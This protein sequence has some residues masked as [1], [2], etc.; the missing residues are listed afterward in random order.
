M[1]CDT[2]VTFTPMSQ[3]NNS[4]YVFNLAPKPE[5]TRVGIE[6]GKEKEKESHASRTRAENLGHICGADAV[7]PRVC[8]LI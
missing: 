1:R 3:S 2:D 4:G 7:F 6:K 8:G 5:V